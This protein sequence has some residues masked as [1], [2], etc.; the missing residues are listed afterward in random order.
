M[1]SYA[2]CTQSI[3][4]NEIRG[5][6]NDKIRDER[7]GC[8]RGIP[9]YEFV[10]LFDIAR[11][12]LCC[13]PSLSTHQRQ[14]KPPRVGLRTSIRQLFSLCLGVCPI[15][16][17]FAHSWRRTI[18]HFPFTVWVVCSPPFSTSYSFPFILGNCIFFPPIWQI[19][20]RNF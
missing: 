19:S 5:G 17:G 1:S 2:S 15:R 6:R 9:E 16:V 7:V 11:L 10:T 14:Q 18:E 8:V 4:S 12:L 3:V 20:Q 13:F